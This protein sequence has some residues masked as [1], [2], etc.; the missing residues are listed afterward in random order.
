MNAAFLSSSAPARSM[1]GPRMTGGLNAPTHA[2]RCNAP[3][4][5]PAAAGFKL[6]ALHVVAQLSF[7]ELGDCSRPLADLIGAHPRLCAQPRYPM[8]DS[9]VS[10][11]IEA[12]GRIARGDTEIEAVAGGEALRT[13][14]KRAAKTGA[15]R[16]DA[17]RASAAR[18]AKAGR[19]RYGMIAPTDVYPLYEN[20]CRAAWGQSLAEAQAESAEIWSRFS[21][22]AAQNQGAWLRS[23]LTP[24]QI[25]ERSPANR[26][27]AFPYT[28]LMVANASVNQ[29]AGFIVTS[30]ARAKA[31]GV[32]EARLAY[33]GAGAAA[34]EPGDVLTRGELYRSPSLERRLPTRSA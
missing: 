12:A 28:K 1:I 2:R 26:P 7:P 34:R 9:P 22:V 10:L 27:I 11:L 3:T 25:L 13:A 14:Q 17:L 21:H 23:P 15:A 8:G 33:V 19:A 29:G 6:D 24:A 32:P 5:K 4:P 16:T 20:A 31:A 18:A 30:L